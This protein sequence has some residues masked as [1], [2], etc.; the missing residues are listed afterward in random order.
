[1]EVVR[2][3]VWWAADARRHTGG[4]TFTSP[5]RPRA[6]LL[7]GAAAL[8]V[9][10][11]G[12]TTPQPGA[13]TP[14]VPDSPGSPAADTNV[15]GQGT[16]LQVD[17]ED[18]VLCLGGVMESYPPQCE[19]PVVEGWDWNPI[20]IK[21]SS[22]GVTWG[23][24]AVVGSW[25]GEVFTLAEPPVPLA[26]YDPPM[27]EPDPRTDPENAGAG[28]E[29]ELLRIQEDLHDFVDFEVLTSYPENGYLWVTVIYDDGSI[30]E[31]FDAVY[32]ADRIAVVSA[33]RE[34]DA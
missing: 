5:A 28:D 32:G 22:G 12:C 3:V 6:A 24:F 26:L 20:E 10:L 1:M 21:E 2:N 19:G 8:L 15:I 7:L 33:L 18:P 29:D 13:D 34:L 4:M 27:Q 25:D 17:G 16:V 14:D 9:A 31:Y 30:Q 23:T 11:A